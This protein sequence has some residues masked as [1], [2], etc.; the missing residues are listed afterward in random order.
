MTPTLAPPTEQEMA[1]ARAEVAITYRALA[2]LGDLPDPALRAQRLD[3]H[4]R[5]TAI[6]VDL[7]WRAGEL[8]GVR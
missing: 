8:D 4:Q 3:R 6:L 5:A 1:D 2:D 7:M